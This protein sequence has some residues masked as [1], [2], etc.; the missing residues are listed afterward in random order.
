MSMR[1][2]SSVLMSETASAPL[3]LHR[4]GN[5]DNVGNV[6]RELDDHRFLGVLAH[7][8]TTRSALS[9]LVPKAAPPCLT[10]GQE[11]FSSNMSIS[12]SERRSAIAQ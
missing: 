3:R 8:L 9:Q 6:G 2:P 1:M 4:L 10:F 12:L 5:R 7:L 11:M